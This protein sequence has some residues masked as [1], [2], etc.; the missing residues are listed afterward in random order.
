MRC[1]CYRLCGLGY[2]RHGDWMSFIGKHW[3]GEYEL[4]F[5]YWGIGAGLGVLLMIPM[6]V[7]LG[8]IERNG[9]AL[10]TPWRAFEILAVAMLVVSVIGIWQVVGIWNSAGRRAFEIK[11][12]HRQGNIFWS[13]AAMFMVVIG[14]LQL[15]WAIS[16]FAPGAVRYI[17]AKGWAAKPASATLREAIVSVAK[18]WNA[19]VP[20]KLDEV[21]TLVAAMPAGNKLQFVYELAEDIAPEALDV[22]TLRQQSLPA[23]CD[24]KAD[25]AMLE[26]GAE[27][28]LVYRTAGKPNDLE[29]L[30]V[31]MKD[32]S[33]I[34][35]SQHGACVKAK[36]VESK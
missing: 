17:Q 3:R 24:N 13:R 27:Y 15:A 4:G 9:Q 33:C 21:T 16:Q 7:L 35:R 10:G 11:S 5:A 6:Q 2:S 28:G 22:R 8:W 30:T 1:V 26:A 14:L 32:C 29:V 36:P 19:E 18:T 25:L 12:K 20:V 34:E 23:V 31:S